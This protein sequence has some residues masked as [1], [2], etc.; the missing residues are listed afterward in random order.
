MR[1]GRR[2][3]VNPRVRKQGWGTSLLKFCVLFVYSRTLGYQR[4]KIY[5]R[6]HCPPGPWLSSTLILTQILVEKTERVPHPENQPSSRAH[7]SHAHTSHTHSRI[8][9]PTLASPTRMRSDVFFDTCFPSKTCWSEPT[10]L[11]A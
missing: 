3:S 8:T 11:T 4:Y 6:N 10:G 1:S 7:A 9:R 2:A 5:L